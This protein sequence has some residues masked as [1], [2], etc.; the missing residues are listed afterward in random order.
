MVIGG[1]VHETVESEG[2]HHRFDLGND[3]VAPRRRA[4][5]RQ[6]ERRQVARAVDRN[7]AEAQWMEHDVDSTIKAASARWR[8]AHLHYTFSAKLADRL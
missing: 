4:N 1:C 7:R 3:V 8:V 6:Q 2:A 5:E